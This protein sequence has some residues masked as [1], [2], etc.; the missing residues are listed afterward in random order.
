LNENQE[1]YYNLLALCLKKIEKNYDWNLSLY[2]PS[3]ACLTLYQNYQ[4]NI[5]QNCVE[6][7]LGFG[8]CGLWRLK[9]ILC[10]RKTE[11]NRNVK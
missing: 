4:V 8:T 3:I 6:N 10:K 9:Q 5:A 1:S 7:S 11:T 2:F